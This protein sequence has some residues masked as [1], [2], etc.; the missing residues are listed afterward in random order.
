MQSQI[1]QALRLRHQP[2]AMLWSDEFPEGARRF[3]EGRWGCIMW[4]VAHAARGQSAACDRR[5]FG[6]FGGGVGMGFGNQY[7]NFPGGQ[8]CFCHFLSSGN[9]GWET[10]RQVA[11]KIKPHMRP[12]AHEEFVK[13]EG[14]L[15]S[16]ALVQQFIDCLPITDIPAATVVF[17]PLGEVAPAADPPKVITFFADPDQFS[18]LV[19]LANYGRGDNENV[20]IPF[21]A[22]CQ[23]IGIYPLREA[24]SQTP[25]AVAGL[26]DLSARLAVRRQL[27]DNLLSFSVP[28]GMYQEME[29]HVA[30]SFLER[31]TWGAL[32]KA[33]GEQ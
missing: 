5:T 32:L 20:I 22:G 8:A 26:T 19:V 23:T 18:A 25:R 31:H 24:R 14:Y 17:K 6:C 7:R 21:A 2:V 15:K 11:E 12:E 9:E 13:G 4:L 28:F 27:G 10:G 29:G 16:P 33:R 1:A 3:K 30:G